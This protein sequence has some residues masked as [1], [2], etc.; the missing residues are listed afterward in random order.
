MFALWNP[1][2]LS[3]IFVGPSSLPFFRD[4][5]CEYDLAIG[6]QDNAAERASLDEAITRIIAELFEVFNFK[7]SILARFFRS[8][9]EANAQN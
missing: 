2:E 6:N 1:L 9:K 7:A 5:D 3:K 8:N 4:D